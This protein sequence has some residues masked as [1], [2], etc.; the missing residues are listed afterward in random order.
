MNL[1]LNLGVVFYTLIS[2]RIK[3]VYTCRHGIDGGIYIAEQ[4]TIRRKAVGR[5]TT[6]RNTR[7]RN[8]TRRNTTGWNTGGRNT[9]GRNTGGRN[10][11]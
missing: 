4:N 8:T 10:T 9:T 7:G 11:T 5:N 1:K 2:I 3:Q 6:G